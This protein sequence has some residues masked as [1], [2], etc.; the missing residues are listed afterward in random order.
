MSTAVTG[1]WSRPPTHL[2]VGRAQLE[3]GA[4]GV[5]HGGQA[6]VGGVLG[7]RHDR[8]AEGLDLGDGRRRRR[9]PPSRPTSGRARPR[10]GSAAASMIPA[11]SPSPLGLR[12]IV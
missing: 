9:R 6:A 7:V 5:G 12:M 4:G 1:A 11:S 10:G 3:L 8:A 2:L